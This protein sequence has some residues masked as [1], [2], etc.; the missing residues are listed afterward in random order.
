MTSQI[1]KSVLV[2]E[3]NFDTDRGAVV[4]TEFYTQSCDGRPE[5][6]VSG[7]AARDP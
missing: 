3:S 5:R 2:F 7:T 1:I 6:F 4:I